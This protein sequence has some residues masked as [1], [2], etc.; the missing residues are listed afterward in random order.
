M[1]QFA[2][3]P[4]LLKPDGNGKLSKRDADAG[5]F[6]VFPMD[7]IDPAT[8]NTWIGFKEQG[9]LQEATVNF[10]AFLGWNPGNQK[11]MFTMDE[12]I[13]EF[14]VERIGKSGTKFDI[15]KAKWYNQQYLRLKSDV[16]LK[17]ML[18]VELNKNKVS[19]D[20]SKTAEIAQLLKER[21]TFPIDMWNEGQFF[22]SAPQSYDEKV[23]TTKWTQ[24][25][26]DFMN[27]FSA[28]LT[29]D[30]QDVTADHIK[31]LFHQV[32]EEKNLK[33]GKVMQ[34]VRLAITGVGAG[35]D[36]MHIIAILG[37]AETTSRIQTALTK[38]T[39]I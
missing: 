10:L 39:V 24:E 12:L 4:L 34:A 13:Q 28:S 23:S 18:E 26:V 30:T 31:H 16:E 25:A 21:A 35:P 8:Q 1:P 3:L 14:S 22:F 19:F 11:E 29:N 32:L 33:I 27:A 5:G 36:L 6:P 37:K 15:N 7:W 9:Y 17:E 38:L 20:P 2:H